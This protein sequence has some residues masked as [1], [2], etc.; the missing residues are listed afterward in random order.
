MTFVA[1]ALNTLLKDVTV[2]ALPRD[3]SQAR[4]CIQHRTPATLITLE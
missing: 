1:P 2:I 3:P 4:F